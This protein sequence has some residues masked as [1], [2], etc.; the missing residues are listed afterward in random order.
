M[1][2]KQDEMEERILKEQYDIRKK[3]IK[4]TVSKHSLASEKYEMEDINL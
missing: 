2:G 1:A 4:N 3:D